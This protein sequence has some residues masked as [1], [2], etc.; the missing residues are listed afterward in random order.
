MPPIV[1]RGWVGGWVRKHNG[2]VFCFQKKKKEKVRRV[3]A[4][5]NHSEGGVCKKFQT[6]AWSTFGGG[7]G[8][9]ERGGM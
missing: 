8:N 5:T 4:Y 6:T 1:R 3:C 7:W 2:A 9:G